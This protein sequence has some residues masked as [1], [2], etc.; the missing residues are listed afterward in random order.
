MSLLH[1]FNIAGSAMNAQSLRLN[2]TASNLANA[3]SVAG[4]E[5]EA[6]RARQ[7][8]FAAALKASQA[9][10]NEAAGVGVRVQ[11]IVESEAP[12]QALYQPDHPMADGN[13]YVYRSNV[14]AVEEMTNMIS[15]SRS[16]QNNVEVM[17]TS[18]ELLLQTLRLGQ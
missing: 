6:Y 5:V 11:G 12:V 8:V 7:P 14:N 2:T 17:N 13:G 16:F 10:A 18:R 1:V 15:A 3:E 9:G 4:S